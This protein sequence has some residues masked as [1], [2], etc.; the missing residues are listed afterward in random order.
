MYDVVIIGAG[1]GGLAAA[2]YAQRAELSAVVLERAP[3]AGGQIINTYEVDNY[4]GIPGVSGFAL[5]EKMQ[6]HCNRLGVTFKEA[7]VQEITDE[8]VCKKI[9]LEGGEVLETKTII[10]ATGAVNKT[11]G[12]PGEEE[13][14]GMGVSYCATCDGAFFKNRVTAVVG[15]GDVAVED[16]IFLA[17]GCKK[18]YLIH[19]RDSFRAAKTLVTA[20]SKY[21]NIELVLDSVVDEIHG[22]DM[23]EA[24]SVH[25][26]KT[27]EAKKLEVNGVFLAV[28][29]KPN[30][31]LFSKLV[32]TTESGWI[33]A[34]E[35]CKTSCP[36][37]YAVGDVRTKQLRQVITAAADG[38]N[39]I[40]SIEHYLAEL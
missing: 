38:A 9:V 33:E 22:E 8:G 24:V 26:V 28:G 14:A 20:L 35:T 32:K 10:A 39:A 11:L 23:V 4:P 40:T 30:S 36:G 18:V 19:R 12:V 15:G 29:T 21:E 34:D 17:R 27:G 37:I 2:I 25:N 16:A 31:E 7:E 5:A 3:V 13:L 1:P 6:E